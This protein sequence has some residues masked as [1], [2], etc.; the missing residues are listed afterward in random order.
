M[1]FMQ[2]VN[3][4]KQ[5][6]KVRRKNINL[7]FEFQN[8]LLK[9]NYPISSKTLRLRDFLATDWEV[10]EEPKQTLSDKRIDEPDCER[11]SKGRI[12]AQN[13]VKIF[14]KTIKTEISQYICDSMGLLYKENNDVIDKIID[15]A[16]GKELVK[17]V[18]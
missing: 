13:D 9:T 1:D 4:M 11:C 7:I 15:D 18:C 8:D 16:A 6:K 2:A 17:G 10:V 12:Y 5:G 3:E 14:I